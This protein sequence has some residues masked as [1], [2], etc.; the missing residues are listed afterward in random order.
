LDALEADREVSE[1][2]GESFVRSFA[3]YKRDEIERFRTWITDWEF[4]EYTNHI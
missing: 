1:L 3:A 2:L 4:E